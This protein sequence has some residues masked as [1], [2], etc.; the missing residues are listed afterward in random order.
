[1]KYFSEIDMSNKRYSLIS[2]KKKKTRK[3]LNIIKPHYFH[4]S[5]KS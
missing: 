1:M 3:F 5:L 2:F 4:K